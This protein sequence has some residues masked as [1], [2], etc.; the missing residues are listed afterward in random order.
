MSKVVVVTRERVVMLKEHFSTVSDVTPQAGYTVSQD[1]PH[2]GKKIEVDVPHE[3]FGKVQTFKWRAARNAEKCKQ[4]AMSFRSDVEKIMADT[5]ELETFFNEQSELFERFQK[6]DA[7]GKP[8][9]NDDGSIAVDETRADEIKAAMVALKAKHADAMRQREEKD[10]RVK[11]YM[12]ET[13]E[14]EL[15]SEDINNLPRKISGDW[16]LSVAEM[17]DGLSASEGF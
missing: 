7:D 14:I 3:P 9:Q 11:A 17:I 5:P 6:R 4:V 16:M 15:M 1:C 2:C 8:V 13:V 10:A 12:A